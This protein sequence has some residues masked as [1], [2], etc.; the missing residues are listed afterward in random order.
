MATAKK[1]KK[2]SKGTSF[3]KNFMV[4]LLVLAFVVLA[5]FLISKDFCLNTDNTMVTH[6]KQTQTQ[7]QTQAKQNQV[8]KEKVADNKQSQ[9]KNATKK[10]TTSKKETKTKK[11]INETMTLNGFWLSSEQGTFIKLDQYGYRI[12]FSNVSASKPIV[13]KYFINGNLITFTSDGDECDGLDGTYTIKFN[14]KDFRLICK[15]DECTNRKNILEA[16]WEWIEY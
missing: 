12:D 8:V 5:I 6:T 9:T 10:E 3:F 1:G 7:T 2:K 13:G 16:N 11:D 15:D 14:K 4:I